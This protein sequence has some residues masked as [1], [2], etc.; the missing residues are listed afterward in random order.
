MSAPSES[1]E[2]NAY[3]PVGVCSCSSSTSER[4]RTGYHASRSMGRV[5]ALSERRNGS[6]CSEE[7]AGKAAPNCGVGVVMSSA[8]VEVEARSWEKSRESRTARSQM[9]MS[10]S[11]EPVTSSLSCGIT[12]TAL[13][14][15]WCPTVVDRCALV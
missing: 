11:D 14:K 1:T 5:C 13:M 10:L 15:S 9:R 7:G 2:T 8:D 3:L 6:G 12:I 4:A